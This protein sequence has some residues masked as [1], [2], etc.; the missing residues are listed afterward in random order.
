MLNI[1][2]GRLGA[3]LEFSEAIGR[4]RGLFRT[5]MNEGKNCLQ[6][7]GR[8]R[9]Q[10]DIM[11]PGFVIMYRS[12]FFFGNEERKYAL[13]VKPGGDFRHYRF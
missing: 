4:T 11:S 1:S 13:V 5:Y 9:G 6:V 2:D 3:L 8:L 7:L 12:L 10:K